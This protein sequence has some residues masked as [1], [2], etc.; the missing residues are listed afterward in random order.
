MGL[1][2]DLFTSCYIVEVHNVAEHR[3][4]QLCG[5][6]L[7]HYLVAV[8]AAPLILVLH[9]QAPYARRMCLKI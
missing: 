6:N 2:R 7:V 3:G 9:V 5:Y 8:A 1:S 4:T